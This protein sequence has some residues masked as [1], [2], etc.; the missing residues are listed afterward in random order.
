MARTHKRSEWLH[1]ISLCVN[2]LLAARPIPKSQRHAL[3]TDMLTTRKLVCGE[4][5][6]ELTVLFISE[7]L[8]LASNNY[9]SLRMLEEAAY[10]AHCDD[11]ADS[12]QKDSV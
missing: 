1:A 12:S 5:D 6:L 11:I 8:S 3:I 7:V 4:R 10:E 2:E 9:V